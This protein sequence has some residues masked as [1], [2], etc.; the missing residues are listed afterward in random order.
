[1]QGRIQITRV[2]FYDMGG[3]KNSKLF[4]VQKRGVW[5]YYMLTS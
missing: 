4:R 2:E 1:M 5:K 3:F